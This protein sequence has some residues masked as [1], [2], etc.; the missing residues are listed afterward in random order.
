[1]VS[2][3]FTLYFEDPYWVG[4]IE[5]TSENLIQ[6]GRIVFGAEPSNAELKEFVL[7]RFSSVALRP[8]AESVSVPKRHRKVKEDSS[9]TKRSLEI[10]KNAMT[11]LKAERKASNKQQRIETEEKKFELLREKKR[12]KR[13]GH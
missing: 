1:M 10:Y 13:Q 5:Q 4:L 8:V 3:K 9:R 2:V 12:K 6:M 7:H 11:T